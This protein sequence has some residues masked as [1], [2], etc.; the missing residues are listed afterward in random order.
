MDNR[1]SITKDST[2]LPIIIIDIWIFIEEIV[3][4][5]KGKFLF[6]TGQDDALTLNKNKFDI[7]GLCRKWTEV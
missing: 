2:R 5:K 4:G 6:D 3:N 1:I 7:S